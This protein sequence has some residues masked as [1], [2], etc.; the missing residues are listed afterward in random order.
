MAVSETSFADT[1]RFQGFHRYV[2]DS[3]LEDTGFLV[4]KTAS[5][6]VIHS[7]SAREPSRFRTAGRGS[8]SP[9]RRIGARLA[10]G[11]A[12]RAEAQSRAASWTPK[13]D[14]WHSW[15]P[16]PAAPSSAKGALESEARPRASAIPRF[17]GPHLGTLD[18]GVMGGPARGLPAPRRPR[19]S[20]DARGGRA[21]RSVFGREA[22][23]S[24]LPKTRDKLGGTRQ[25]LILVCL[26]QLSV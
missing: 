6:R 9:P 8:P 26:A 1:M 25:L 15:G 5:H 19:S 21:S 14:P 22:A 3:R 11:R 13:R 17:R 24:G 23:A 12:R 16:D 4:R 7:Q 2:P 10:N 20:G 18:S